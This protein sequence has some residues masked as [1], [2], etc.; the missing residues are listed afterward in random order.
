MCFATPCARYHLISCTGQVA[1]VLRDCESLTV[2]EDGT[3]VKRSK[4]SLFALL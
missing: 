2:S 1:E 4:V 3:K